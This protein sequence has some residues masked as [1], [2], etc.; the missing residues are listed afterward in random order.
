M[1]NYNLDAKTN[2]EYEKMGLVGSIRDLESDA[3]T[4]LGEI[5]GTLISLLNNKDEIEQIAADLHNPEELTALLGVLEDLNKD[6]HLTDCNKLAQYINIG[7]ILKIFALGTLVDEYP[8]IFQSYDY[9]AEMLLEFMQKVFTIVNT[10]HV[11]SKLKLL[12][13][14]AEIVAEDNQKYSNLLLVRFADSTIND[15]VTVMG[16]N[17]TV[18]F[19]YVLTRL[20]CAACGELDRIAR[21][22]LKRNGINQSKDIEPIQG[23]LVKLQSYVAL[24]NANSNPSLVNLESFITEATSKFEK[25]RARASEIDEFIKTFNGHVTLQSRLQQGLGRSSYFTPGICYGHSRDLLISG[26]LQLD[27]AKYI[28]NKGTYNDLDSIGA[29]TSI[30]AHQMNQASPNQSL[31]ESDTIAISI[32][33]NTDLYSTFNEMLAYFRKC[34]ASRDITEL[35]VQ[36]VWSFVGKTYEG[37]GHAVAITIADDGKTI[38]LID[39][40]VG[41]CLIKG[42]TML[43]HF[44]DKL[45]EK[46]Y[47]AKEIL[48][49]DAIVLQK[50]PGNNLIFNA[51]SKD[52]A[53]TTKLCKMASSGYLDVDELPRMKEAMDLYDQITIKNA[54][55]SAIYIQ[56]LAKSISIHAPVNPKMAYMFLLKLRTFL[57]KDKQ[58]LSIDE[59][60]TYL[61]HCIYVCIFALSKKD[62]QVAKLIINQLRKFESESTSLVR[63]SDF[64][65]KLSARLSEYKATPNSIDGEST[66]TL[67]LQESDQWS[68]LLDLCHCKDKESVDQI[69]PVL[70][71]IL[72]LLAPIQ[73]MPRFVATFYKAIQNFDPLEDS[74][75]FQAKIRHIL[76]IMLE[77]NKYF[78]M[79]IPISAINEL[80]DIERKFP[81]EHKSQITSS[82]PMYS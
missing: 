4:L 30:I 24:L 23:L 19:S 7:P 81:K 1:F 60:G 77:K 73:W 54:K 53:N 58:Q 55:I 52:R 70:E 6:N 37:G 25:A 2:D 12:S 32:G 27:T 3:E 47:D 80:I 10:T 79:F 36:F 5:K 76:N 40:N 17:L 61:F 59:L 29:S 82:L 21:D 56:V 18:F 66:L 43:F 44:L 22:D 67:F 62:M 31:H 46:I 28:R 33:K 71:S 48:L 20:L 57:L 78:E 51:I 13:Y 49:T 14:L 39:S 11:D 68:E 72:K 63:M 15:S 45:I 35:R 42:E 9:T 8:K 64:C 69:L 75:E 65:D 16:N 26:Q 50:K 38:T 41:K 74:K 34:R